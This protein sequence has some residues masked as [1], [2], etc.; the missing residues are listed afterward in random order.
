[1]TAIDTIVGHAANPST[2]FT[3]VT[4][5]QGDSANIRSFPSTSTALLERVSRGGASSGAVRV[6]SPLLHDAIRGITFTTPQ[7]PAVFLM[8]QMAPQQVY[9]QDALTIQVT[10]GTAETDLAALSIYY[11]SLPG[12]DARLHNWGDIASLIQYIKPVEVDVTNSATI[13]TWTDT[14]IT[15]TENI[16]KANRDYAVL[17]YVTDT[18][19]SVVGIKGSE[20]GNLRI[21][22]PGTTLTED[23]SNY[24]VDWSNREGTPHIPV[25][26]SANAP[27]IFVSTADVVASSTPK[28]QLV[29]ALLSSNLPS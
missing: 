17:G 24:F 6:T 11:N 21:C 27:S 8:P 26:N 5:N 29:L 7:N 10:G 15:T 19:C 20:T 12:S 18:A 22:G 23:T 4:M 3:T 28:V 2:T 25:V 16:L 13:G 9:P 14:V 1:M